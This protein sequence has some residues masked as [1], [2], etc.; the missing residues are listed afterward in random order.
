MDNLIGGTV[1]N[2]KVNCSFINIY[3]HIVENYRMDLLNVSSFISV[4]GHPG[5]S[6]S[7]TL[8][9]PFWIIHSAYTW[10]TVVKHCYHVVQIVFSEI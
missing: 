3:P 5:Y 2:L 6:V 8:V 10:F 4:E 9:W 1:S 7:L